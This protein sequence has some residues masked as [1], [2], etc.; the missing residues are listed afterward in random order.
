MGISEQFMFKIVKD[1]LLEIIHLDMKDMLD[2]NVKFKTLSD[3][4]HQQIIKDEDI[5]K[6]IMEEFRCDG[7]VSEVYYE[8]IDEIVDKFIKKY[9][10]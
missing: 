8:I 1:V 4:V 5:P 3:K 6:I 2:N 9:K 10:K 7:D